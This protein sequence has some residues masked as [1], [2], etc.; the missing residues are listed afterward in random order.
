MISNTVRPFVQFPLNDRD[1]SN[2]D[3]ETR[4]RVYKTVSIQLKHNN[5]Y[6]N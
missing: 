4:Q 3:R 2:L 6:G 5:K 1:P